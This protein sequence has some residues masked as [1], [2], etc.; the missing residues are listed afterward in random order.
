MLFHQVFYNLFVI[1]IIWVYDVIW[2]LPLDFIK[3]GLQVGFNRSFIGVSPFKQCCGIKFGS[4]KEKQENVIVPETVIPVPKAMPRQLS[5]Q[6]SLKYTEI[7]KMAAAPPK[8]QRG[9][10]RQKSVLQ[11]IDEIGGAG[12]GFYDPHMDILPKS[13]YHPTT[14]ERIKSQ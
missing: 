11:R 12:A 9:V 8:L 7:Q 3:F 2:F 4:K 13:E 6:M 10:S 1:A 5:R 14:L